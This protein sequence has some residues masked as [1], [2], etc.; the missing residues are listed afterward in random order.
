[1]SSVQHSLA[2]TGRP[3][4]DEPAEAFVEITWT[5]SS[6]ALGVDKP[7]RPEWCS[8][9]MFEESDRFKVH[10]GQC[11][12]KWGLLFAFCRTKDVAGARECH[13]GYNS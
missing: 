4:D 2:Y 1:M 6:V 10:P 5:T 7:E 3:S 9:C 13:G 12:W 8:T 11:S